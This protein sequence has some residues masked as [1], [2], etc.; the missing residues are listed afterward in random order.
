MRPP[1]Q[2]KLSVR[3]GVFRDRSCAT[4]VYPVEMFQGAQGAQRARGGLSRIECSV[5][6]L[7]PWRKIVLA[8]CSLA[9]SSLRTG[10][11]RERHCRVEGSRLVGGVD[12]PGC[13]TNVGG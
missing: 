7:I 11:G 8:P 3:I 5:Q 1:M 6:R 12:W 2:D 13:L 10:S 4:T 9:L